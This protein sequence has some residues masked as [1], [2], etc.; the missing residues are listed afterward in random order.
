MAVSN[1]YGNIGS[2]HYTT[3]ALNHPSKQWFKFDDKIVTKIDE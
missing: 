3:Y 2:G 1:H